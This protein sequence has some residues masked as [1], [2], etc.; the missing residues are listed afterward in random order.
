M[1]DKVPAPLRNYRVH[2]GRVTFIIP[3]EFEL[4]LSV[5]EEVNTSQFF[6][7]D[8]RFS[9]SPSSPVPKGRIFDELDAKVNETLYNEGLMGCFNFLHGLVLTNKVNTLFRQASD[10][11]RGLWS[12]VLR[13]EFLHRTL[14]VQYW[15]SRTGPKS[16]LEIGI[17][18]GQHSR[19]IDDSNSRVSH[20]GLRWMRDGRQANN[21][22]IQF[23]T[24]ILSME[25]ILRSVIALHTS[26]LLSSA[27]ATLKKNLLFSRHVLSIRAQLSPTEPGECFL[28][29]QMTSSQHLRV[30]VEPLSGTITLSGVSSMSER[31]E[32]ERIQNRTAIEEL[33]SRVSRLRCSIAV[34]EIESGTKALGLESV[35]QRALGIDIRRLF[36]S[37]ILRSAFFTHPLWD[38]QWA[39]AATSSMDGDS[40]WLIQLQP[41]GTTR[42]APFTVNDAVSNSTVA[43]TVCHSLMFPTKRLDYTASAELFHGLT[44]ILA[45]YANAR[46]LAT[47]PEVHLHPPVEKLYLE[48]DL[49]VPELFFQ[50]RATALPP[51]LRITLPS[52]LERESYL[53]STIRLAF[54]GI[55]RKSQASVLVAHG[56][57]RRP[58]RS[59]LPLVSKTDPSILIQNHGGGFALR[60]LAPAGRSVVLTLFERLQRL[61]CVLSILRSLLQKQMEPRSL[62]LSRIAF[63]YGPDKKYSA[64]FG[65]D[66]LGP[67]PSTYN[68]LSHALSKTES[69]FQLRLGISFDSPSPHRRIQEPLTVTLNRRFRETGVESVLASM[70]ETF[71]L[72]QC[73]DQITNPTQRESPIVHVTVRSATVFQFHYP[74]LKARFRL[75]TRLKQGRTVWLLENAIQTHS[76]DQSQA[77]AMVRKKIYNSKGNGWQGLADGA[78]SAPV[79]VGNLLT[80]LHSCLGA[81]QP[82]SNEQEG[83]KNHE[84]PGLVDQRSVAP[85]AQPPKTSPQ[86]PLELGKADIITID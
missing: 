65:I 19:G 41:A 69:L 61:E 57:L 51:S 21:D 82:E 53:Q 56:S 8:I 84:Q 15:P 81:C 30:S 71:P 37:S 73:L 3:G 38:R 35:G 1:H 18:R 52:E 77:Y 76:A 33:L 67:S 14:V 64:Q 66:V 13:I 46:C 60:L 85:G 49:R 86:Q 12:D 45:I 5:A 50:Y 28:N 62:S 16:W 48:A 9:F 83:D 7:V 20:L 17:Q 75:S 44:G 68:D 31:P 40:W 72:L 23:D 55:D 47:L 70:T 78:V 79:M 25:R 43:Q 59:L 4:D 80:E 6:F 26:Y 54:H 36:P 58:V 24:R 27:Y 11:S 34:D 10:L 22:A 42:G 29:V 32:V 74:L 2:D 63:L 39:A